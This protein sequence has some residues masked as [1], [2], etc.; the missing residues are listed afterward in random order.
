VV[1]VC[2]T[3]TGFQPTDDEDDDIRIIMHVVIEREG[4]FDDVYSQN[5]VL[6]IYNIQCVR[7]QKNELL[8]SE[9]CIR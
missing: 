4:P 9:E 3:P 7:P 2:W 1:N 8:K 5:N 6:L